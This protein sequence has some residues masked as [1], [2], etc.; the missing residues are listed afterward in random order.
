MADFTES[1]S[2]INKIKL[3]FQMLDH[4]NDGYL[5]EEDVQL[6]AKAMAEFKPN[7]VKIDDYIVALRNTMFLVDNP[8]K[9]Y[10]E[11]EFLIATKQFVKESTA[12]S[13]IARLAQVVFA[14]LDTDMD[15]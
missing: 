3:R 14:F 5:D 10:T 13:V 6:L 4:N 8:G 1:T 12:P 7:K 9:R 2:W 11:E 15:G